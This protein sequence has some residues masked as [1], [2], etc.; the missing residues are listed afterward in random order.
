[1]LNKMLSNDYNNGLMVQG[2]KGFIIY[3]ADNIHFINA[4]HS[5]LKSFFS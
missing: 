3:I 4:I 1:M 5:N 2:N